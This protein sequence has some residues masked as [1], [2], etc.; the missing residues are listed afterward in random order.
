MATASEVTLDYSKAGYQNLVLAPPKGLIRY[1]YVDFRDNDWFAEMG[2]VGAFATSKSTAAIDFLIR[3]GIEYPGSNILLARATLTDLKRSTLTKVAQ[4]VGAV[5]DSEN[6]N[7]AIY[8]F[9]AVPHPVTGLD[10]QTMIQGLGLDRSDLAQVFKS[11]EFHTAFVEEGDEVDSDSHDL[12]QARLRQ[13]CFHRT[14]TVWDLV[15]FRANQWGV[16]PE[17]AYEIMLD[18]PKHTV[19]QL[20]LAKDHPMPGPTV[21]K[22]AWNPVGGHLWDRYVGVP[23]PEGIPTPTWVKQHVGVR[24]KVISPEVIKE[25]GFELIAGSMVMTKEGEHRYVRKDGGDVLHLIGGGAIVKDQASLVVQRACIYAFKNENESRDYKNEENSYLMENTGNRR[26]AFL[27]AGSS[28]HERV[29]PNYVDEY[30]DNGGNLIKWPGKDRAEGLARLAQTNYHGFGGIDQGGRHA[31]AI[32]AGLISAE[33]ATAILYA[34]YVR[35]GMAARESARDA[36]AMTLP[37]RPAMWW[38]YDPAMDAKEYARDIE[39][40]IADEYRAVLPNM[41]RGDRG[42]EAFDYVNSMLAARTSLIGAKP[43][44]SLVIFD[45][46]LH[47]R[48]V[49]QKLTWKMVRSQRDK[50]EVDVGDAIKIAMSAFRKMRNMA[51]GGSNTPPVISGPGSY[52]PIGGFDDLPSASGVSYGDTDPEAGYLGQAGYADSAHEGRGGWYD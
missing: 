10:T 18:D 35:H 41:I 2:F 11:T 30:T 14:K 43:M 16:A 45:N 49:L 15:M 17:D 12:L 52:G 50:W 44:P 51:S 39:Y 36:L 20:Q 7:E 22:T 33:T 9:P 48:E 26:L 19:G 1:K 31:T 27:G 13:V 28:R 47:V 5:F 21:L 34:E 3:R 25:D 46:M 4:R 40:S 29:F 32:I 24:N 6:K 8:R 38:G 37:N 42:E 23:H